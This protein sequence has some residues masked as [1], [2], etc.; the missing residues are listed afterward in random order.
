MMELLGTDFT[1]GGTHGVAGFRFVY[2]R[3]GRKH[4]SAL[5]YETRAFALEAGRR[6]CTHGGIA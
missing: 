2:L 1:S 4:W 6:F 3:H 5:V